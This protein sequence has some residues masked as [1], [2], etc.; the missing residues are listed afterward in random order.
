MQEAIVEVPIYQKTI[1]WISVAFIVNFSGNF[2]LFL[3]SKNSDQNDAIFRNQYTVIYSTVTIIKNLL[4]CIS[5]FIKDNSTKES[6]KIIFDGDLD[7][8]KI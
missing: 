1:F 7:S 3:F 8:I 4:L 2:F 5:V 6:N